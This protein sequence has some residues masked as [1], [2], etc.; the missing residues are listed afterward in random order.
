MAQHATI[1]LQHKPGTDVVL[2]MGMMRVIVD[3]G[4]HDEQFIADR[5]ENFEEF[6]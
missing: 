6:R 4:L 2:L 1:I 5:C 3:E